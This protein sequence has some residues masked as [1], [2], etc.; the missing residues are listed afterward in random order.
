MTLSASRS[1]SA[2]FSELTGHP[3]P[4][5][6]WVPVTTIAAPLTGTTETFSSS[7]ASSEPPTTASQP[8]L[9]TPTP[10]ATTTET[11]TET[12]DQGT[13]SAHSLSQPTQFPSLLSR[14]R[15][16]QLHYQRLRVSLS[17][18]LRV[19]PLRV[20]SQTVMWP[21]LSLPHAPQHLTHPAPTPPTDL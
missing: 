16:L 5:E 3:T 11:T 21:S 20:Q 15:P 9:V 2:T 6:L 4:L 19:R 17:P 13:A 12:Q 1:L 18:L 7:V 10:E 8:P 14:P